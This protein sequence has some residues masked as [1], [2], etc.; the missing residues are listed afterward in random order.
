MVEDFHVAGKEVKGET[1]DCDFKEIQ[2]RQRDTKRHFG[3]K[4]KK[5]NSRESQH[6]VNCKI[7]KEKRQLIRLLSQ[8]DFLYEKNHFSASPRGHIICMKS[9]QSS[10]CHKYFS[11]RTPHINNA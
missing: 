2:E 9:L 8:F 6:Q 1:G 4:K 10:N 7:N 3:D 5:T 11:P